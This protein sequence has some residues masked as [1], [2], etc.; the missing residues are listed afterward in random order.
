[1]HPNHLIADYFITNHKVTK[2]NLKAYYFD[3]H[4][5]VISDKK[6]KRPTPI[7]AVASLKHIHTLLITNQITNK[8][9]Q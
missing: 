6:Q 5:L 3:T 7:I 9:H 2:G 8:F 4:K 1:L